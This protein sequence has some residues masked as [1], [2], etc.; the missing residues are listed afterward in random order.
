MDSSQI[1]FV[2]NF[3]RICENVSEFLKEHVDTHI[4]NGILITQYHVHVN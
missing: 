1:N 4:H 3:L 2:L